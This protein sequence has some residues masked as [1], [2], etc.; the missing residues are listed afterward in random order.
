M[1][2]LRARE[3]WL[4]AAASAVAVVTL[5]YV[6]GVEAL[7]DR[8]RTTQELIAARQSLL[9]RDQ[10][11]L[12]RQAR[13][14]AELET[15]QVELAQR[16]GRL[17]PGD[18]PPIAASELQKLVKGTAQESGVEVRSERILPP[19]DRGGYTEVPIEVTLSGPIRALA[20]LLYRLEAAPVTVTLNDVKLRVL[21]VTAPREISAT[22]SLAGYIAAPVNG[23]RPGPA[24]PARR[25]G[26]A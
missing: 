4:L 19:T 14:A 10:R 3:R 21:S 2:T 23:P 26:G 8:H 13:Y 24:E 12:G 15:L 25:P 18:K 9:V 22:L 11:L 7:V 20:A 1:T 6:Y 16:R 5:G 17:L